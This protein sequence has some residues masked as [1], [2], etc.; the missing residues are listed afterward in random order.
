MGKEPCAGLATGVSHGGMNP[1][2]QLSMGS[3]GWLTRTVGR[4]LMNNFRNGRD[5]NGFGLGGTAQP[6]FLESN[7]ENQSE[8]HNTL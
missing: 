2:S 7:C 4:V 1:G 3:L 8:L 6:P 5:R